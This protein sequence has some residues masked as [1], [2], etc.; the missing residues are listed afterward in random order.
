MFRCLPFCNKFFQEYFW[1]SESKSSISAD[2]GEKSFTCEY[3]VVVDV[4]DTERSRRVVGVGDFVIFTKPFYIL[5]NILG[6]TDINIAKCIPSLLFFL[7]M[8]ASR[9]LHTT[10]V[11]NA[12]EYTSRA[13]GSSLFTFFQASAGLDL[14]KDDPDYYM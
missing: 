8:E 5:M 12:S 1:Q 3:S 9:I 6:R 10:R 13:F 14:T 7:E 4:H 11:H 2:I